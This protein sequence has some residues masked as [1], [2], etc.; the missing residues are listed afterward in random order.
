MLNN[1]APPTADERELA[2]IAAANLTLPSG[3]ADPLK[4]YIYNSK[5][6]ESIE[7]PAGAVAILSDVLTEMSRGYGI[8]LFPR[9]AELTTMEAAD[10]LNVSRPFVIKLLEEG[11]IPYR[12]VGKHRRIRLKDLLAYKTKSDREMD[13]AMDELAALSQELGLYDL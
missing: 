12:L 9:L 11:E 1:Y 5:S 10:I 13:E 7:L 6:E 4:F 8:S 2:I 3:D